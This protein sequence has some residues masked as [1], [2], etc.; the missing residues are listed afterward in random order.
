MYRDRGLTYGDLVISGD[1][2]LIKQFTY[3]NRTVGPVGKP[4]RRY[5]QSQVHSLV[6][7]LE[8][9]RFGLSAAEMPITEL[10]ASLPERL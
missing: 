10:L 4:W 5:Y 2:G 7:T 9:Q 8:N 1:R 3:T 6:R